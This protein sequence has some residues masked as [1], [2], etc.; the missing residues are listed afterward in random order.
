MTRHDLIPRASAT[1]TTVNAAAHN[2][3]GV[4]TD[5]EAIQRW[6]SEYRT[7]TRREYARHAHRLLAW[8]ESVQLGLDTCT[9]SDL[10]AYF[11]QLDDPALLKAHIDRFVPLETQAAFSELFAVTSAT[12]PKRAARSRKILVAMY[13]WL[14]ISGYVTTIAIPKVHAPD[15]GDANRIEIT[16]KQLGSRVLADHQWAIVDDTIE[17]LDWLD[18]KQSRCRAIAVW[19][20][21]SGARKHELAAGRLDAMQRHSGTDGRP[22]VWLWEILG[23][24]KKTRRIPVT[25]AMIDAYK[26]Y[27]LSRGIAFFDHDP[28]LVPNVSEADLK[29][30]VE[31]DTNLFYGVYG[32]KTKDEASALAVKQ[33]RPRGGVRSVSTTTVYNDIRALA[34]AASRRCNAQAD[35]DR[36]AKLTPHWFRH[37]RALELSR[38]LNLLQVAQY[39]GHSSID[40]TKAYSLSDEVALARAVLAAGD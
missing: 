5:A 13:R 16:R 37:R 23:K 28:F 8:L 24:G 9:F 15:D 6:L 22:P 27:R 25:P 19:L 26:R 18:E 3:L 12:T 31:P 34:V 2:K 38:R 21:E 11:D 1:P 32:A 30:G 10:G 40:T 14:Q 35:R 36:V 33:H 4:T 20:R 17:K 7:G 29:R 39:L